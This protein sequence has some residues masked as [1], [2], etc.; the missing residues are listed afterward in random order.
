MAAWESGTNQNE[1]GVDAAS[2][3]PLEWSMRSFRAGK[4]WD[5]IYGPATVPDPL[6]QSQG[7][8][9]LVMLVYID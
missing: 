4:R 5:R 8:G 9:A 3:L 7:S 2:L 6:L 1:A